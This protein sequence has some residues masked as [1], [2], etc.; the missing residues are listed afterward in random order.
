MA[1]RIAINM[2]LHA[3]AVIRKALE[4]AAAFR[5][6]DG[7]VNKLDRAIEELGRDA[8]KSSIEMTPL[9]HEV[10]KLGK[11]SRNTA[12]ELE[13]LDRAIIAA[14]R[15]VRDLAGEFARTG[16]KATLIDLRAA[17]TSLSNLQRVRRE[18][19]PAIE[20]AGASVGT[21]F[22]DFF[23]K[24]AGFA[25]RR[26]LIAGVVA[27]IPIIGPM[28]SG[29]I[30]GAAGLGGL[31]GGVLSAV[32]DPRVKDAFEV[33]VAD[34]EKT[35][36][37]GGHTFVQPVIDAL[38]VISKGF[39]DLHLGDAFAKA[40]P[41][42]TLFAQG[43]VDLFK[44]AMPGF[45]KV[46]DQSGPI[47]GAI[48]AGLGRV[49]TAFGNFLDQLVSS[50]GTLKG[51]GDSFALVAG[52]LDVLGESLHTLSDLYDL[53]R[54]PVG[55][56]AAPAVEWVKELNQGIDKLIQ[57]LNDTAKAAAGVPTDM[58]IKPAK[59][60]KDLAE[61]AREANMHLSNAADAAIYLKR[62]LQDLTTQLDEA[63]QGT[64]DLWQATDDAAASMDALRQATKKSK[65]AWDQD[66]DAARQHHQ[67]VRQ[68]I[69]DA[70]RQRDADLARSNGT[71]EA[72]NRILKAYNEQIAK[73]AEYAHQLGATGEEAKKIAKTYIVKI[74]VPP[75]YGIGS[76]ERQ[77]DQLAQ[78]AR[79][80]P[81]YI[82]TTVGVS[83]IA[84]KAEGGFVPPGQ[85]TLVGERGSEV[86]TPL[87]PSWVT[88]HHELSTWNAARGVPSASGVMNYYTINVSVAAGGE[89]M[90]ARRTVELIQRYERKQGRGWRTP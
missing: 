46:M 33:F 6:V 20:S 28:I 85:P 44:N 19:E 49:G 31:V 67:L 21:A 86:I 39:A 17:R 23:G 74:A 7:E 51:L 36:F 8:V 60:A 27:L 35:F 25:M 52:S 16:A 76:A 2:D 18:L 30:V 43:I 81:S 72:K 32:K 40:A 24:F 34:I 65:D 9:N 5:A 56:V 78:H 58:W 15:S 55:F 14:K 50:P 80:V 90:A 82:H 75:V 83:W 79:N 22:G 59:S 3:D 63:T 12:V 54:G 61:A 13:T 37:A 84:A 10:D 47:I 89:D 38:H 29:L 88:P 41:Y 45:N 53:L 11:E 69:Q 62:Q 77:L 26:P 48:S 87:V 42:V 70:I 68:A 64:I 73:I 4:T 1:R 57:G 66:S 71:I